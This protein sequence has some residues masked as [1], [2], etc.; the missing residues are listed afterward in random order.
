MAAL[1]RVERTDFLSPMC[2]GEVAHVS[3]EITYTSRHSVE[4]QVHVMSENILTGRWHQSLCPSVCW[5][6]HLSVHHP[7]TPLSIYPSLSPSI[8]P[9]VHTSPCS[10]TISLSIHPPFPLFIYSS[11][12][13]PI[14]LAIPLSIHH[15]VLLSIPLSILPSVRPSI[16]PSFLYPFI[17]LFVHSFILLPIHSSVL[18]SF[19]PSYSYP[20]SYR[21]AVCVLGGICPVSPL[22]FPHLL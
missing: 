9:S 5:S 10:S 6:A 21:V 14:H 13:L 17:P 22:Q 20:A 16:R 15:F 18:L 2:I 12:C 1:A 3:A 11:I 19:H 8:C 7:S 4:V